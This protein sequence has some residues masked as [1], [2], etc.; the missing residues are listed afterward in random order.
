MLRKDKGKQFI[1]SVSTATY[2]IMINSI[3]NMGND[4]GINIVRRDPTVDGNGQHVKAQFDVVLTDQQSNV[5]ITI[6]C[7][8][9]TTNLWIQ[10]LGS[11][12][13][14]NWEAKKSEFPV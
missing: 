11:P 13:E 10:L 2:V 12:A 7:Q 1:I 9:T 8:H 14:N 6:T 4:S 3:I 5:P